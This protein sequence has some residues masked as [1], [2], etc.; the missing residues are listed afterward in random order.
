[1]GKGGI[2]CSE[3]QARNISNWVRYVP[4]LRGLAFDANTVPPDPVGVGYGVSS[5]AG[6]ERGT[7]HSF[8]FPATGVGWASPTWYGRAFGV[9]ISEKPG[10]G[11]REAMKKRWPA[12]SG[13]GAGQ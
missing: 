1:M 12:P 9:A 11:Y 2:P 4:P 10:A 6:L 5:L 13:T 7:V 3:E 8:I